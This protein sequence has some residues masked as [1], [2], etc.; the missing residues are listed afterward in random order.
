MTQPVSLYCWHF[1]ACPHLPAD[2]DKRYETGRVTCP[3]QPRA[4]ADMLV[5]FMRAAGVP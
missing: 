4:T 2:F 5:E 1:M 3:E